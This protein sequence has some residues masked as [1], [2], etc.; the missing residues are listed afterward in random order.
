M[1]AL[2]LQPLVEN[3][4][5]H[6]IGGLIEGGAIRLA[7]SRSDGKV[8]ITVRNPFDPEM[9]APAQTGLGLEN[10]RR[11]LRVRYGTDASMQA[12]PREGVYVVELRLPCESPMASMRRA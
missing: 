4:V 8:S 5:K 12:G 11:R 1:P 2:L 7:A 6:G 10:V 3:A 9:P